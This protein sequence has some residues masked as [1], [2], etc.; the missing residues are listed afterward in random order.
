[1]NKHF[2]WKNEASCMRQI[3]EFLPKI[4]K[5]G[6]IVDDFVIVGYKHWASSL[7]N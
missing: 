1:M 2:D 7:S 4:E 3:I 5:T 6:L